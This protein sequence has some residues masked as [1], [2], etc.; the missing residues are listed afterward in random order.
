MCVCVKYSQTVEG[1]HLNDLL[2]KLQVCR[3]LLR[4]CIVSILYIHRTRICMLIRLST[5]SLSI[6]CTCAGAARPQS[7]KAEVGPAAVSSKQPRIW[8]EGI[9]GDGYTYYYNNLTGGRNPTSQ[10]SDQFNWYSSLMRICIYSESQW[11]KPEGFTGG[12]KTSRRTQVKTKIETQ[13]LSFQIFF[14]LRSTLVSLAYD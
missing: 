13:V 12:K 8:S 7:K 1:C 5:Q 3:Y 2:G 6:L 11:E 14:F 9:T 10:C 4:P